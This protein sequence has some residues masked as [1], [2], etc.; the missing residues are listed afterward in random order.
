MHITA[1]SLTLLTSLL[2]DCSLFHTLEAHNGL[3]AKCNYRDLK[4]EAQ[5][6][7]TCVYSFHMSH[8]HVTAALLSS[9]KHASLKT[10]F[11]SIKSTFLNL[12]T[13]LF[14]LYFCFENNCDIV[15]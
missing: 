11:N 9:E 3:Q 4:S 6:W 7:A 5:S 12:K 10:L 14:C 1:Y 8:I 15:K 2:S 13:F